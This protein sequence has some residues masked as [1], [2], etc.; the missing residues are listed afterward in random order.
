MLI[1]GMDMKHILNV[2]IGSIA[3]L[4]ISS[5]SRPELKNGTWRAT[6]ETESGVQVP[7]TFTLSDSSGTKQIY[8]INGEEKFK[9]E[10]TQKN[11]S[12]FIQIP[13]FDC[14]IRAKIGPDLLTGQSIK[15]LA[16]R[17]VIMEFTANRGIPLRFQE[18]PVTPKF[19]VSGRWASKFVAT[20]GKIS[21][22]VGEFKQNG[23]RLTGTFL[24]PTG[25]YRYLEGMVSDDKLFL[26]SFTGSDVYLFSA[27]VQSDT[28]I[29][30]GKFYSG[31]STIKSWTA[32][33]N[34]KAI[35]PSV[36]SLISLNPYKKFDFSFPGIDSKMISLS[37]EKFRNKVV[38]VQFMGSWCANC[39]DE[40]K[41][42]VPFYKDF[43]EKG[44][45]IVGL[46]YERSKD[47]EK[48]KRTLQILKNKLGVPYDLLITGYT[49]TSAEVIESM[50]MLNKFMGFPTTVILD[51]KGVVRKVHTGFSGPG[52]G[53][54]YKEFTTE[55]ETFIGDLLAE[56]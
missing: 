44:V 28:A 26:S 54:H 9:V 45:E 38:I 21:D 36:D 18:S 11:D 14:E 16:D 31:Y 46:A 40:T 34:E 41:Y 4:F 43:K 50:P 17:D 20:D 23:N 15:H 25:D 47:F 3:I 32:K 51:K 2:F 8:I 5:C 37:D 6:V 1:L 56:K 49:H 24:S 7:F 19:N 33:R 52:T 55:F 12:L 13:P 30:D 39:L 22:L 48:A 27:T 42:F 29:V 10:A 53:D 35:P